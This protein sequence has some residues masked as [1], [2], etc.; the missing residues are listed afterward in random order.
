MI[1]SKGIELDKKHIY[2]LIRNFE[3]EAGEDFVDQNES[4]VNERCMLF[5]MLGK[6][7]ISGEQIS[8]YAKDSRKLIDLNDILSAYEVPFALLPMG[9]QEED[10]HSKSMEVLAELISEVPHYQERLLKIVNK[11]EEFTSYEKYDEK[12][13]KEYNISMATSLK[14]LQVKYAYIEEVEELEPKQPESKQEDS[15][16]G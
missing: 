11:H 4:I 15:D 8:M 3:Y 5:W 2:K 13:E 6:G 9:S 10:A 16:N 1:D 14:D 12:F 7:Y